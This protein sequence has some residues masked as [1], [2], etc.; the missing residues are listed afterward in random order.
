LEHILQ[1]LDGFDEPPFTLQRL[2]EVLV[3]ANQEYRTTHAL[4]NGLTRLLSVTTSS[5]H[6]EDYCNSLLDARV[7]KV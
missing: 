7:V 5:S 4:M 1:L 6:Y 3:Q 2:A